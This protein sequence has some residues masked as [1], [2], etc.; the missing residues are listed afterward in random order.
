MK[1]REFGTVTFY[2]EDGGYG[3]VRRDSGERD[4]FFHI[5][6]IGRGEEPRI[7]D[8]VC[9]G[10]GSDKNHRPQATNMRLAEDEAQ[11]EEKT[12]MAADYDRDERTALAAAL[13]G[14]EASEH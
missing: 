5:S 12:Q 14:G 4:L 3:F 9:F 13:R 10:V 1:D 11:A 7:G 6:A 8:R 2:N